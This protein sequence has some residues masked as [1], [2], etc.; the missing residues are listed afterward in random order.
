MRRAHPGGD[1]ICGRPITLAAG[2]LLP[3]FSVTNSSGQVMNGYVKYER[4]TPQPAPVSFWHPPP[5]PQALVHIRRFA[6]YLPRVDYS[7]KLPEGYA[8]RATASSTAQYGARIHVLPARQHRRLSQ[9]PDRADELQVPPCARLYVAPAAALPHPW[10]LRQ[11]PALGPTRLLQS[12]SRR[13]TA[14][15]G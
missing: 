15:C 6:A 4:A 9:L 5:K 12:S 7:V 8:L 2:K 3:V 11:H 1:Q 14:H 13:V 10:Q